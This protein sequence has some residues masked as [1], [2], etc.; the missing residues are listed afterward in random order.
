MT[1]TRSRPDSVRPLRRDPGD[2]PSTIPPAADSP[3][4]VRGPGATGHLTTCGARRTGFHRG[5]DLVRGRPAEPVLAPGRVPAPSGSVAGP[6]GAGLPER[7]DADSTHPCPGRS[8]RN[9][10]R[11]AAPDTEPRRRAVTSSTP[12]P[13]TGPQTS[14][15]QPSAESARHRVDGAGPAAGEGTSPGAGSTGSPE[16]GSAA[17]SSAGGATDGVATDLA[18]SAAEAERALAEAAKAAEEAVAEAHDDGQDAVKK[19]YDD[20]R[21]AAEQAY[22]QSSSRA[23]RAE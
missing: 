15:D 12:T 13:S 8:E 16:S 14:E 7:C 4:P 20:A 18:A 9:R 3:G 17:A 10:L 21:R 23:D 11:S 1:G 2:G 6:P 5:G 19:G 22:E